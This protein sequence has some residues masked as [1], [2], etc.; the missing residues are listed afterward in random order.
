M[1]R[2]T[3]RSVYAWNSPLGTNGI[4]T[5]TVLPWIFVAHPA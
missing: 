5:F 1:S 4:E 2:D 3:R